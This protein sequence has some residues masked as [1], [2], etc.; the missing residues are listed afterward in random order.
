MRSIC[1]FCGSSLGVNPLF[2]E[3]AKELARCMAE[4]DMQLVYGGANVGLMGVIA[5]EMLALNAEVIGVMPKHISE[6]E[7]AHKGLTQMHLVDS[8]AD[9]KALMVS[10][11]DGFIALPGGFGTLD[12][13]F[14]VITYN[15]LELIN[16]PV[17]F[18][19]VE[20]YFDGLMHFMK[21]GVDDQLLRSEHVNNIAVA[22][23]PTKLIERM[24]KSTSSDL[25]NWIDDIKKEPIK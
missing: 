9:R 13:I 2:V 8:M 18:L 15:Q 1:V 24:S 17:G 20:G 23:T 4:A 6:L 25:L 7:I 19:N 10:I 5:N 12:E 22:S 3:M 11:S 21:R 14:E 16:K